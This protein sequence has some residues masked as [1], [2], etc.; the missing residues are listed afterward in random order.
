MSMRAWAARCWAIALILAGLGAGRASADGA[1]N[2]PAA[3]LARVR[4]A[5]LDPQRAVQVQAQTLP[6]GPGQLHLE[7]G[8]LFPAKPV[9]DRVLEFVFLGH[10]RLMVEPPDGIEA[11]QLE[12]FTD[13]R[14]LDV[15]IQ[16]AVL[17]VG[18]AE[19]AARLLGGPA[20][21]PAAAALA[22]QAVTWF[23]QW[24]ASA[25]RR[26]FGADAAAW[27]AALG[28]PAFQ[29]SFAL[30]CRSEEL[31]NFYYLLDPDDPEQITLGAF[32]AAEMGDQEREET[33]SAIRHERRKGRLIQLRTG[34][35]GDWD[36]WLATS[37]RDE[38][39]QP[40]RGSEG[41]EPVKYIVDA[42]LSKADEALRIDGQVR[43]QLKATEPG[44]RTVALELYPDLEVRSVRDGQARELVWYRS[45]NRVHVALAEA[46]GAGTALELTVEYG[47]VALERHVPGIYR[48]A[49]TANW[50]PHAGTIDHAR[51]DVTLH[52]PEHLQLMASGRVVDSGKAPGTRWEHRVLELPGIAFSFEVGEYD[53]HTERVGHVDL[54][55]AFAKL[56]INGKNAK[57]ETITTLRDALTFYEET[58]GAYPLDYLTVV[59]V[60]RPFSQGYPGFITLAEVLLQF[61]RD[62]G[63]RGP[64]AWEGRRE[65][66]AHELAHQWW[67]NKVG[68]ES[69]RDQWLSEALADYASTLYT[70]R[71]VEHTPV[72]LARHATGWRDALATAARNGLTVE[73]LGPV[74][75]G[76]RLGSSQSSR[77]YSAVVYDKGSVVFSMLARMLEEEP[78][79]KMLHALADAVAGRVVTTE[80]FFKSL[81]HMSGADLRPFADQFVYG[82]GIPEVFYTYAIRP[83][84]DG[85][86]R[87]EGVARQAFSSAYHYRL[88]RRDSGTWDVERSTSGKPAATP[89]ALVVPFQVAVEGAESKAAGSTFLGVKTEQGL[90]GR[91]V[92]DGESTPFSIP[93]PRQPKAFWLD[94]RGEV[95]ATFHCEACEPK[96]GLHR[97]GLHLARLGQLDPAEAKLREALAAPQWSGQSLSLR[98]KA[99]NPKDAARE[100]LFEDVGIRADLADLLIDAGR[101]AEAR[102]EVEALDKLLRGPDEAWRRSQRLLTHLRLDLRAGDYR[103]AYER[104]AGRVYLPFLQKYDESF[105]DTALRHRFDTGLIVGGSGYAMFAVAA[106][107]TGHEAV[108]ARAMDEAEKRGADVDALEP[109]VQTP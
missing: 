77:A 25:E 18:S 20:A 61:S 47:G 39:G 98:D 88:V 100:A 10:G 37:L 58:F 97:E 108:A 35:L 69:Y 70:A 42:T 84:P 3:L 24:A 41:F 31:G 36:T 67:G 27:K 96:R 107:M 14:T 28:D 49:D 54:T 86:W 7:D 23:T 46:A 68:W 11:R 59:T 60:P 62:P 30:W 90:G 89:A 26:G 50:H 8:V 82:T 55:V 29:Q 12:L 76:R 79:L 57:E 105:A 102:S 51:Y 101:D 56:P 65:T 93:I 22:P 81:T 17:V 52:W 85:S 16:Q 13:S 78:S 91:V 74:V 38:K 1:P 48:L 95:L 109:L 9:G 63:N 5:E 33:E 87:V 53:V 103:S 64:L 94:Q 40:R 92:L 19:V 32:V 15:E 80:V 43:I 71:R 104:L 73:S 66:I 21:G 72:Y 6:L 44:R 106:H 45:G 83:Q 4:A 75:L 34:D 2:A 99:P